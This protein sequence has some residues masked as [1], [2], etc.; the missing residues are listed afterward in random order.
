M[1]HP[2][3]SANLLARAATKMEGHHA[4]WDS[5]AMELAHKYCATLMLARCD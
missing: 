2:E 5:A 3:T 4:L 1:H